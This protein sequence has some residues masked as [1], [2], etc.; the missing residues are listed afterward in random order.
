MTLL[1]STNLRDVTLQLGLVKDSIRV[2][3]E[4]ELAA[5]Q[6]ATQGPVG[7]LGDLPVQETPFSVKSYTSTFLENRQ[8]LTLTDALDSDASILSASASS[9]GSPNGDV[10]LSRG[11]KGVAVAVNGLFGLSDDL[12]NMYFVDRVDVF[13]GPSAFVMGAPESVGGV[14]N[15][16]LKRADDRPYLLLASDFVGKSVYGARIDASRRFAPHNAFGA[17]ANA[18]YREG[19]G[20]IRD[21]RLLIEGASLGLDFKSKVVQLSLDAQYLRNYNRAFQY[22]LIPVAE[23]VSLPRPMPTNLST[24]PVWMDDTTSQK[25][26][27]GRA[28]VNL[29]PK[30]IATAGS[31]FSP[32]STSI[33]G[34]CPVL[35]LDYFGTIL[36]E[37]RNQLTDQNNYSTDFGLR[38]KVHTGAVSHSLMIGWNRV[39]DMESFGDFNDYG[40]SQPYNLYTSYRPTSPNY[41]FPAVTA[42]YV[43]DDES[44]KGWYLGDTAGLLHDRLLLTGGFRRTIMRGK[45]TYRG[46]SSS[47]YH[48]SAFTP[49]AAALFKAT[50]QLSLYGNFIQALQPGFIAPPDTKNAGEIFPPIVSNQVEVGAKFQGRAWIS[51]IALYRISEANGVVSTATNPPTFSQDGRQV[52]TGLEVNFAGDLFRGLHAI[53]SGSFIDSRQRSTGDPTIEGKR[54]A[55]VPAAT[56]RIN[57]NWDIPR[58]KALAF[59]CNLKFTGAAAFDATNSYDVPAWISADLGVRYSFPKERPFTFRAQVANVSNSSYWISVFSGGLAPS[60]PRVVTVSISKSF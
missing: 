23:V 44:T 22:V 21:S 3:E 5:D 54:T 27:L 37:Q 15:L 25:A 14:F 60:G 13:S 51:T 58:T 49:S 4:P 59:D 41:S 30:W 12:T 35:L 6:I 42:D 8:A 1:T 26:I 55:N 52:N 10:F 48:Q 28:D 39:H 18:L 7:I 19:E 43:V 36:C 46:T 17:R 40:P 32:S 50:S 16:Q 57:L 11:F 47:R 45:E 34:Y 31:G 56:E 2:S 38:G 20:E 9:R 53:L 24:Q 33:P 29:S